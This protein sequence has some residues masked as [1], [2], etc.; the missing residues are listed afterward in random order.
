MYS[1]LARQ[2]ILNAKQELIAY[3]L[4][5]RDGQSN[6]FPNIDP[7]QATSNILTNNHLTMGVEQVT[8]NATAYINF[9]A[10]TL[11]RHFPSFLDP[12]KIVIEILEDVPISDELLEACKQLKE[13]GYTLALD[14]H[15][16]DPKWDVF[17]PYVD[18]I[19]VDVLE[20][21]VIDISRYINRIKHYNKTLL[22]ERVETSRQFEQLKLLGFTLFQG[23]FFAKPEMMKQKKIST[24]KH[25][26]LELI[27]QSSHASLD[28]DAINDIFSIDPG[29]TYKLLRFIN[30][31][32]YGRSQ[33][34]TSLK[35]ALIYIGEVELKKFIALLALSDLAQNKPTEIMR[36]SLFRAKFCEQIAQYLHDSENPP[37][38]FLTGMLS[39]IDG[40]LDYDIAEVINILPIDAEIK[41]A[42]LGENIYLTSYLDLAKH[43]EQGRWLHCENISKQFN[44]P[45]EVCSQAHQDAMAWA[46]T[47]LN[48]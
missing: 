41:S 43:A 9:H 18:I 23:Y 38:A 20:I 21:S 47:M 45:K 4:L 17:L 24:T 1:Y 32:M 5:F 22:A 13:K 27:N 44:I 31:P 34:I 15:D 40:I 28:F 35:H 6:Y 12:Q 2:P 37:K 16:F 36:L 14:D 33:E 39:L 42:L 46:D 30:S 3:E 11:I 25:N 8:G 7:D 48:D 10:D 26:I 19:K 29:L